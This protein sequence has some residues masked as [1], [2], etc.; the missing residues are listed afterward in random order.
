MPYETRCTSCY[1]SKRVY[2]AMRSPPGWIPCPVCAG[3]GV[4][5]KYRRALT[6]ADAI[7]LGWPTVLTWPD[8]GTAGACRCCG[9]AISGRKKRW[10]GSVACRRAVWQRLYENC[11]WAKRHVI[12]RDGCACR[13][14]GAVFESSIR[15]GGPMYPAPWYLEL[16]H[17]VPLADGGT[18]MPENLQALC[19]PC[20]RAK[21][22]REAADRAFARRPLFS[23]VQF[24][25]P[26][27]DQ[28]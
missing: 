28:P 9:A 6:I 16:D 19:A 20:H 12:V 21:T 13:A 5:Q 11:H 1:G 22:A 3:T 18:E 10:C 26:P 27:G 24:H 2:R 7:K 17:I 23:G 15:D 8:Y 4:V 14:C 25:S